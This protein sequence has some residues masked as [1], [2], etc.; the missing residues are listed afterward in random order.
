MLG[1]AAAE[2]KY[3]PWV[4]AHCLLSYGVRLEARMDRTAEHWRTE[5]RWAW[6]NLRARGWRAGVATGLLAVALAAN[7][8]LF[9]V[10]DSV[11]F[12]RVP[13]RDVERLVEIQRR[14]PRSGRAGDSLLSAALLDEWRKQTDLFAGVHAS[15]TKTLFLAGNGEP[16]AVAIADVTPGLIELLGAHPRWGRSFVDGDDRQLDL[17]P[18]LIAESLAHDRFGN[19]GAAVGQ[20][21]ETTGEPLVV[22]GVMPDDFRF[23]SGPI[24]I[25][26]ALDPHGPLTLNFAGVFSIARIA[27]DV[28]LEMLAR[29]MEQ[30]SAAI[31][32]AAGA[33][34]PYVAQPG[35]LRGTMVAAEQ[36]R[37]FLL[38][39]GAALC[40]L[41]IACANVASLELAGAVQR[42]RTYA[43][44]LAV[45]ASRAGL[46]RTAMLEGACLVGVAAIGATL[47]ARLGVTALLG[48]LPVRL[49]S[50]SANPIDLDERALLFMAA[51]AAVT[52]LL[53]SLPVVLYASRANLVELLKLEGHAVASSGRSGLVRRALTVAEVALAVMLLVGSVLYVRSYL[54]L[55]AI[56]KGFDSTGVVT[57]DLS[58]PPQAYPTLAEKRALVEQAIER[59]RA[60]PGVVAAADASPPP[61]M[62]AAYYAQL[63]IDG[64]PPIQEELLIAE[65]DVMPDYF[66][67]LRV[68]LRA[69]RMFEPGDPPTNAIV[70]ETFAKRYWPGEDAIGHRFRRDP[71][72]RWYQI[73]GVAGHVRSSYDPP[74]GRSTS[75][76][77]TYVP[78]QPPPPPA[79]APTV[80]PR[81]TGGSFGFV[82]LM[83]RV[84]SRSRARDLYQTVRAIDSRFIL[85]VEFVDDEYARQFDDRL[86]AMRVISGFGLLAFLVAAA[87]IYS[88]MAFLV[89]HRAHEIGIRMALGAGAS[90]INR[91]VLGSSLR[92]VA[93][94]SGLGVG[95][96]I[97]ASRWAESQ[98]FGVRAT[99]P[100]T[101]AMV[102]SAVVV[103]ALVATWQPARQA[104]RVDPKV[105]LRN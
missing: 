1:F 53:S 90:Q 59:L 27:P 75:V 31:G 28:T 79:P 13:Y 49:K 36:R 54:A 97:A 71:R 26:R 78:R 105:L 44:Q 39:T 96:A 42:A 8:M 82:N 23:P 43:I 12:H 89:A 2:Q 81:S 73:V 103:T 19:P 88:V 3:R 80:K 9:A 48:Y 65:L 57:I 56:E 99:D 83:V 21:L 77:Q 22:V 24:R 18:V 46:A 85:K 38:L 104:T 72:T 91:L 67:V 5:L 86:L 16:E 34:A 58:I 11:V 94:G 98:L 68:P 40:L 37:L 51:A 69:G 102:T 61:S 15:L 17:Q 93:I 10:A 84:D 35:S 55:L 30:R 52:W 66:S 70:D 45:G 87:G 74:G 101:L 33:R 14:D 92:L 62:G 32:A 6:R 25:W 76:Y 64:R 60:R 50:G 41:L 29:M 7:A 4:V 47:L 20:K 95:G 100:L 63:E